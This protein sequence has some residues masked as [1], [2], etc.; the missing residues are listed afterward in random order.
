METFVIIDI[1]TTGFNHLRDEI[2][3]IAAIK[4][5]AVSFEIVDTFSTLIKIKGFVPYRIT[6]LTGIT[7][8]MLR[9]SGVW[10]HKALDALNEFCVDNEIYAHNAHFDKSFIRTYLRLNNISYTETNWIDTIKLFKTAFPGR[11]TYKL[12]SLIRDFG[13]ANKEDHRALSDAKHTLSL[14]K[15][16][17]TRY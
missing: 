9:E 2:T 5:N 11:T 1:E 15:I 8:S 13:L 16:A 17:R 14:L 6:E 3:E 4:V 10:I 12:E 7:N